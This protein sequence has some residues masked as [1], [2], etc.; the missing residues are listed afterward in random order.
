MPYMTRIAALF[1]A[2][3]ASFAAER[4]DQKS[5]QAMADAYAAKRLAEPPPIGLTY[6][7]AL[8]VQ[9]DYVALLGRNFGERAGY[10]VGLVTPVGQQRYKITH[11]VRG[12]LF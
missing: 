7:A 2:L 1:L 8:A 5:L 12:V 4:P 11:P 6:E 3:S 10:K 9:K